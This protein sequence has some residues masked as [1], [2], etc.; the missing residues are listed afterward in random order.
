MNET[1]RMALCLNSFGFDDDDICSFAKISK[2]SLNEIYNRYDPKREFR[3][4]HSDKKQILTNMWQARAAEA[5]LLLGKKMKDAP[6]QLLVQ[7]AI[8]AMKLATSDQNRTG[9]SPTDALE[10]LGRVPASPTPV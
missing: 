1:A 3:L 9:P 2:A 8:E 7:I 6:P 5:L 10:K 4:T